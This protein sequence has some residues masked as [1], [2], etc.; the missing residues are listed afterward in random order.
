MTTDSSDSG[1]VIASPKAISESVRFCLLCHRLTANAVALMY[2]D[3]VDIRVPICD[4]C[5]MSLD[6]EQDKFE[7]EEPQP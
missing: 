3:N 7:S 6:N 2:S 4:D 5:R 1:R